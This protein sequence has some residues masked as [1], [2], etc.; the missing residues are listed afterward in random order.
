M[1]ITKEYLE[2]LRKN[3]VLWTADTGR[4]CRSDFLDDWNSIYMNGG[5]PHTVIA[6]PE[7]TGDL[8]EV[9]VGYINQL[10]SDE[11]KFGRIRVPANSWAVDEKNDEY[12]EIMLLAPFPHWIKFVTTR[13]ADNEY[14][15]LGGD[16][17]ETQ[18]RRTFG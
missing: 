17:E 12:I 9:L 6:G 13:Y 11:Q 4:A 16:T 18:A 10:Q 3:R 14:F 1:E 7:V 8:I 15:I 2:K 5:M